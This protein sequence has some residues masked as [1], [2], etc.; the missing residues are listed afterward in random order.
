[1]GLTRMAFIQTWK[2]AKIIILIKKRVTGHEGTDWSSGMAPLIL[3][4]GDMSVGGQHHAPAPFAQ[5]A[6][7]A[8]GTV[9]T[10][11]EKTKPLALDRPARSESLY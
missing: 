2:T 6:R 3:N 7:W 8:P 4:T 9:W 11:M 1:M 10:D 5:E